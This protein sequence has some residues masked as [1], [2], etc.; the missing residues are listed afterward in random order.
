MAM[1]VI[2][3]VRALLLLGLAWIGAYAWQQHNLHATPAQTKHEASALNRV[4]LRLG[5][6]VA[7]PWTDNINHNMARSQ[8]FLKQQEDAAARKKP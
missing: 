4:G 1:K 2:Q 3:P 8:A 7:Q 6:I 5:T